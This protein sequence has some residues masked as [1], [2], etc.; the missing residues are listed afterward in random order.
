MLYDVAVAGL[1]TMG[2]AIAAT[3]ARRGASVIGFEQFPRGHE[4]GSFVGRSRMI[5]KAY[6]ED[7]AYVPLLQRAYELWREL[8]R[9]SDMTL[10]RLT[11]LLMVGRA[12]SEIIAGATQAARAHG[13]P[14]DSLNAEEIRTRYPM[15]SV[16]EHEVGVYEPD[17]GVLDPE[18][19]VAAQLQVAEKCGAELRCN[20][21]LQ[22]WA[23]K[24]G[25]F[26]GKLAD[27]REVSCRTLVL[28]LGPWFGPILQQL[29]VSF[30]VQRNVQAWFQPAT[31]AFA[32]P[33]FPPFLLDRAGL[34]APL[35]G[36]PNLGDGV[37]A[38]FHA[39][40]ATTVP[41]EVDREIDL[42]RDIEPI[43]KAIE[44]W[45]PGAAQTFRDAKVCMYSLTRDGHFV[46]DR[47]PDNP[48]L[49]L[50]GGF[51]G[52][53]FKFAPIVGEIAADLALEGSTRHDIDFL[54][55]RRFAR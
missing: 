6:F 38:A 9:E 5:R 37:K 53:G 21:A 27:G 20:C 2:S 30:S 51:S 8:E 26:I 48:Q 19:A 41:N 7:P 50:C 4:F 11:G 1:G 22:S 16:L 3:C 40:G 14:V 18:R 55:L 23:A 32:S 46:V 54:S 13:L 31:D 28:S 12:E 36:F 10:L 42:R 29:G 52:H 49:I 25:N 43:R 17:G 24:G 45:M 33:A 15:L 35:Y 47:H 39:H 44:E 34:P